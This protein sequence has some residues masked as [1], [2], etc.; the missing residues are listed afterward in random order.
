MANREMVEKLVGAVT[1][2]NGRLVCDEAKNAMQKQLEHTANAFGG[3]ISAKHLK[4]A[5]EYAEIDSSQ[6]TPD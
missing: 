2:K 1:K 3:T 5:V 4:L 6:H